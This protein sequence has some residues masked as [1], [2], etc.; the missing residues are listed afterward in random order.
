[1]FLV[2]LLTS[3]KGQF[4]FFSFKSGERGVSGD[5]SN[6]GALQFVKTNEG[7]LSSQDI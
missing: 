5:D 4:L 2:L 7:S 1:M 3:S 6:G